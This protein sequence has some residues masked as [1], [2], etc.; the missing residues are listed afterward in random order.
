[1]LVVIFGGGHIHETFLFNYIYTSRL[2]VNVK[3]KNPPVSL[4]YRYLTLGETTVPEKKKGSLIFT[5]FFFFYLNFILYRTRQTKR[6]RGLLGGW[7][8]RHSGRWDEGVRCC[9]DEELWMLAHSF[10]HTNTQ[11]A[12]CVPQDFFW[13]SL[14]FPLLSLCFTDFFSSPFNVHLN[15]QHRKL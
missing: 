12:L 14:S 1:M 5:S 3:K 10:H 2:N 6:T 8:E 4:N 15:R 11:H 7:V 13:A 9:Y